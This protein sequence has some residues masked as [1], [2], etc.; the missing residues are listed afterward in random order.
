MNILSNGILFYAYNNEHIN[1]AEIANINAMLIK[2]HMKNNNNISVITDDITSLKLENSL[3]DQI[4]IKSPGKCNKR[5]FTYPK[6]EEIVT[7]KNTT[8]DTAYE[9]SPYDN[10]LLL[11]VDFLIFNNY[12]DTIFQLFQLSWL[13]FACSSTAYD[14]NNNCLL[15]QN[16]GKIPMLWATV[17]M[18]SK[19]PI[20]EQYF[21]YMEYIRKNYNYFS[22]LYGFTT[23]IFRN[24]YSLTIANKELYTWT[25][26]P[27]IELPRIETF[28]LNT[29]PWFIND[30][31]YYDYIMGPSL[32]T[33]QSNSGKANKLFFIKDYNIHIM[34]KHTILKYGKQLRNYAKA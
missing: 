21:S 19:T 34:N 11:D 8:R 33:N 1:Y 17:I 24:D 25:E 15:R 2:K 16:V 13:N 12:F 28:T 9:L 14:I 4:I 30:T 32:L 6:S 18:F 3:F 20:A 27:M 22:K 5:I 23:R 10:T 26:R 7:W 29:E 31:W